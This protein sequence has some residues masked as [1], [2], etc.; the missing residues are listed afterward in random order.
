MSLAAKAKPAPGLAKKLVIKPLKSKPE[1]PD[2]FEQLKWV[3]LQDAINAVH[4]KRAVST[5]LEELYNA[6]QDM[7]M[8]KMADKLYTA[9]QQECDTHVGKQVAHLQGMLQLEPVAFL[10]RVDAMW[11]DH[12]SQMLIIRH[13]FLYLDRTYVFSSTTARSLFD[14]GLQLLGKHLAE[15]PEVERHTVEGLLILVE[16]ERQGETVDRQLMQSLLRMM[17]NL[18][19]YFEAF[20]RP[21]L[22]RSQ[23]YY[24]QEGLRLMGEMDAPRYLQHCESRLAAEYERCAQ[25]LDP[26]TRKPLILVVEQQLVADHIPSILERGFAQLMDGHRVEDVARLY[27][28]ASR[29]GALEALRVTFRDYIRSSGLRLIKDEEKDK[30]MVER[31]LEVKVKLDEVLQKS[32]QRNEAFANALKEAFESFINQRQNKPAELIAKFIDG[33]LRSGNKGQTEEEL[34][35]MLDKVLVLFRYI[36]GKDVFEA[37]YKKDLAKRLLMGKSASIDAEKSM[38]S[39]LKAECGSQF[40]NKLEG[41]FKD[42]ELSADIMSGFRQSSQFRNKLPKG[43]DM[44]VSVLTSGFWPTYPVADAKLPQELEESQA[45]F[46][47]FYLNK[48][49]GRKL[50][51]HSPL[52]TCVLRAQFPKGV[53]ELSVSLFQAVV[54]MLFNTTDSLSFG[55][56]LLQSGI[57]DKELRRTLQSLACGKV[58]VLTKEPKGKDVED[59]D[60]FHFNADFSDRLIRIKINSIQMKETEEENKKTNDQVFQDRQYQID[61]ALVRIMKARKQLSH[62]L[63]VADVIQQLKFPFKAADLKKRIESLIDREFLARDSSDQNVYNYLA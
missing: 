26:S 23:R 54:L 25:Y 29:V 57:E 41:M 24:Q 40:T 9:L 56:I 45:V 8:H 7:C 20:Q 14:M 39:K 35:S 32:L 17:H 48:Y 12:C 5:S 22:E 6:V 59:G 19:T 15:R 11:R 38:I 47:E 58:R 13:I 55:D 50:V 33:K 28:L 49:S 62:K 30:E 61:A 10:D 51:W 27:S 18:G 44:S 16:S 34:E 46:K 21:F 31:L 43:I 2:N 52:G 1:L 42:I 63:L 3:Q 53:K 60:T 37:F 4:Q 36:Q